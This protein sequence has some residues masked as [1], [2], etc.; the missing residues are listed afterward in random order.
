QRG[1][2]RALT[3]V[4]APA[5]FGKTTV[6][7]QWL[8]QSGLP[9]AW[10]SLEAEDN[11]PTRF[12]SYLIAA[13]QTVDARLGTTA[14]ALLRTRHPPSAEAVLSMLVS[15]VSSRGTPKFVLVLDDYHL[16]TAETI[17][18]GMTFLLEH[19]PPQM[20]LVL[21]TRADPPLPLARLRAQGQLTEVRT[22]DLR[23]NTA[24][25]SAF[26]QTLTGLEL[27]SEAIATLYHHTEGWIV[28]L[29]LAGLSLQGR[30]DVAGFLT[31]F[32]GN[33]RYVLDYLSEEVLWRQ[34]AEVQSF[35]L[36]TCILERLSGPL[37]D[38]VRGQ[39]GSQALLEALERANLF[40]VAL[41]DERGWYR[42][43]HLFADVLRSQLQHIEPTLPPQLHQRASAWYEQHDLPVEA[44]QHA[45]AVPDA[46]LAA[47]L[48]EAGSAAAFSQGQT[49]TLLGWINALP[50]E[51]VQT[52][53]FLCVWHAVSLA[54]I[55]RLEEA[56]ARLQQAERGLPGLPDEQAQIIKS[57]LVTNR[58][59]I[60]SLSGNIVGAVTL[61]RQALQFLPEAQV[62]LR[63]NAMAAAAR[64]HQVSGDVTAVSEREAE[65]A[66]AVARSSD[67]PFA[68]M[69][70]MCLLAR[71]YALQGRLRLAVATYEQVMQVVP[72]PELLPIMFSGLFYYFGLS[73][74]LLEWNDLEAA[75]RLL[76]QGM[77]LVNE[78]LT[79]EPFASIRGYSALAR[80]QQVRGH[81]TAALA[82]LDAWAH[83]AEQRHFAP[84][85]LARGA[86]IRAQLELA[87]GNLAAALLWAESSGLSTGDEDL[88]Y[89]RESQYLALARVRLEQARQDPLA[90]SLQDVLHLLER[91]LQDAEAKA[92]MNSALEI[93]VLRAL[94]LEAQGNRTDALATL[95]R[96]L[97]LAEPEGYVRLFVDEGQPMLALLR[98]AHARSR[99]PGYV[100]TLLRVFGE[101]PVSEAPP[102]SVR[103]GALAEPL[104][105]REREVLGLLLAGASN[106]EI[107][108]RLVVSVN[109]V[110]RHVYNLCSKLGVQSRAQAIVRAR[111]LNIL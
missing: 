69:S 10:L 96:V 86:A 57:Y 4:S 89:V 95:E 2:E 87:Q 99:V 39:E 33:H 43:H 15:E 92:R 103:A 97:A 104:T 77:A 49:F 83:L 50:E 66:V 90:P 1:V 36:S 45:L 105:V 76:V 79:V 59:G 53:P 14:L 31:A 8:A 30:D 22:A 70:S 24:E 13:L 108:R 61:A 64:S 100:A 63:A 9:V 68:A 82:T 26:L 21:A 41:D 72:R 3:L 109:T 107:A 52:R 56:E 84:H 111:D 73:D 88:P 60:A 11:D 58:V 28:G 51:L 78:T 44:V 74:L 19:L 40:V 80:L 5:G 27:S 23:F 110:K 98:Q 106:R 35:L 67:D 91:L 81:P 7:A 85:L 42:Y 16:I 37:C 65:R 34:P 32:S 94:A 48:I 101:Q 29:Q 47:R 75:E 12:L 54:Q 20:R 93:L 62:L 17:H 71:L 46:E 55:N 6:L 102:S 18:R 38:A 25:A